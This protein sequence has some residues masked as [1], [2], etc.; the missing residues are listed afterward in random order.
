MSEELQKLGG[1]L[2]V[3]MANFT[4]FIA[5]F[6]AHVENWRNFAKMFENF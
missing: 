6:Q 1:D 5:D 3:L 2:D 4:A